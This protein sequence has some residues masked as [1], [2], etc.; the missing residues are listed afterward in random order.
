MEAKRAAAHKA[1]QELRD[2]DT[3]APLFRPATGRP[4]AFQRNLAA[5]PIGE[6]LYAMRCA[7]KLYKLMLDL[8]RETM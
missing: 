7:A 8:V 1:A 4:P 2:A 3:G 6:Y 5:L